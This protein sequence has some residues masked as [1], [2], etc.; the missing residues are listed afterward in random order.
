[1]SALKHGQSW[2]DSNPE[3]TTEEIKEKQKEVEGICKPIMKS[4]KD[5]MQTLNHTAKS[6]RHSSSSLAST[7]AASDLAAQVKPDAQMERVLQQ[8]T[9]DDPIHGDDKQEAQR[10]ERR[11]PAKARPQEKARPQCHYKRR[12]M[13]D[14]VTVIS[15]DTD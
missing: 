9:K 3:A 10:Q 2:L 12:R 15:S 6:N 7:A 1:M 8:Q 13:E 11:P 5:L 4:K 14:T